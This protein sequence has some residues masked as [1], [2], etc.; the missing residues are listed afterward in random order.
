MK[1]VCI[2]GPPAVGKLTVAKEL[3]KLT[4]YKLFHNHLSNDVVSTVFKFG[5][6]P[7]FKLCKKIRLDMFQ[8]ASK[9][10]KNLIYTHCFASNFKSDYRFVKR[11]IRTI[12]K[13]GGKV[14]FV[15]LVADKKILYKRVKHASRKNFDK[16]QHIKHLKTVFDK[17]ELF[18]PIPFVKSLIIDNTKLSAKKT[19]ELIKT[20]YKL[21]KIKKKKKKIKKNKKIKK[22]KK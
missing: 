3:A 21:K 2:Y 7:F 1:L 6:G 12:E 10:N 5:E 19:A 4:G 17:Y 14:C 11:I 16:L 13:Y 8:A 18:K 22:K 20:Y 9:Y 15:N